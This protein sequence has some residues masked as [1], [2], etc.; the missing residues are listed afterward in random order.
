MDAYE[1]GSR[2][3][4]GVRDMRGMDDNARGHQDAGSRSRWGQAGDRRVQAEDYPNKRRR[5]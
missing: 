2:G 4:E 3:Y 5:Y 1:R